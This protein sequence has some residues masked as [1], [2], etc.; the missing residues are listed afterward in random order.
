MLMARLTS[1]GVLLIGL[2]IAFSALFT[3]GSTQAPISI[4]VEPVPLGLAPIAPVAPPPIAIPPSDGLGFGE[5]IVLAVVLLVVGAL[6]GSWMNSYL[7]AQKLKNEDV[8]VEKKKHHLASA[9]YAYTHDG[10]T[11]EVVDADDHNDKNLQMR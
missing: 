1:L 7:S 4:P 3:G 10:E 6:L 5:V 2:S 8:M 9:Q 11:L